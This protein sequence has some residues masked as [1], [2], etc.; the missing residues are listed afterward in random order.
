M[1]Q[2]GSKGSSSVIE[3]SI[4]SKVSMAFNPKNG[5]IAYIAGSFVVIYGVK[6]SKQEKFIK[7]ERGRAF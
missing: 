4:L 3:A 7:N 5:D 6:T 2:S 1:S